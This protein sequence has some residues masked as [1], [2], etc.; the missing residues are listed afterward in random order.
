MLAAI[1]E[2]FTTALLGLLIANRLRTIRRT[3]LGGIHICL[4]AAD[5]LN[6]QHS[7]LVN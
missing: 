7:N 4:G 3:L 1:A 5:I 6:I 2:R